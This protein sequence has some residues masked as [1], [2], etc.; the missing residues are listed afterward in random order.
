VLLI[1]VVNMIVKPVHPSGELR[2]PL[3]HNQY[4][5]TPSGNLLLSKEIADW[6]VDHIDK[7]IIDYIPHWDNSAIWIVFSSVAD[8]I[9]FKLRW[10]VCD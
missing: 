7:Y 6:C 3:T 1:G 10:T 8:M 4:Q 2:L 5:Y 9:A